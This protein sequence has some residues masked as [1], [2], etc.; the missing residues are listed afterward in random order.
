MDNDFYPDLYELAKKDNQSDEYNAHN[1]LLKELFPDEKNDLNEKRGSGQ[2][3]NEKR[4]QPK[5]GTC[6]TYQL[7]LGFRP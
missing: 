4:F 2:D 5:L 6:Q 1:S 3:S 7:S